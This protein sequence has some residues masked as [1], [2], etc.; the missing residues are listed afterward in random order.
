MNLYDIVKRRDR[1]LS[2]SEGTIEAVVG[3]KPRTFLGARLSPGARIQLKGAH[4]FT[5]LRNFPRDIGWR[6]F[7]PADATGSA[8]VRILVRATSARGLGGAGDNTAQLCL[9]VASPLQQP[10]EPTLLTWP[11][12]LG[13]ADGFDIELVNDGPSAIDIASSP[14]FNP[15]S[16]LEGLL[17]GKGIEVGPGANPFVM[18]G[19][20]VDVQYLEAAPMTEWL[21]NY[22]HQAV[23]AQEKRQLWERYI[24]GDAQQLD[25][26]PD[27]SLDFI[28]S[29]HV[30]EH[31][32]NPLAVLGNWAKKLRP[33]GRVVCVIPDA[34]Y[35]FDLRQPLS[36]PSDWLE[37]EHTGIWTLADAKYEKW[38]RYT[39]PYNT[40]ED[41]IRRNY[42]IHAHYYTS[43]SYVWIVD[44]LISA[45][46]FAKYFIN[47]SPNNKD[48]GVVLWRAA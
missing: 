32:V 19:D 16:G 34:R 6:Y 39:A 9:G 37:E 23:I 8:S 22:D 7:L 1:T 41:L 28:F 44:R 3:K 17:R 36:E 38:R 42:S 4:E 20:D 48:F 47:N 11:A 25:V 29:S 14:M 26:C 33:G 2:E 15:R 13:E 5:C 12:W 24:I 18:P 43:S 21:S 40:T 31:F 35:C 30:F 45:G 10:G 27:E 46:V